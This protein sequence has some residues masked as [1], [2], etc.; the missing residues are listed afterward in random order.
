MHV[1]REFRD[2]NTPS[3][4]DER[5]FWTRFQILDVKMPLV[6]T[7]GYGVQKVSLIF[8]GHEDTD[9]E[10]WASDHPKIVLHSPMTLGEV[11]AWEETVEYNP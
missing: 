2:L 4:T 6:H 3:S 1:V 11:P 8:R 7:E 9:E 10:A 5:V